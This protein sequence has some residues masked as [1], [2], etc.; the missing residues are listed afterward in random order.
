MKK[1]NNMPTVKRLVVELTP[2]LHA[3]L[4]ALKLPAAHFARALIEMGLTNPNAVIAHAVG[5]GSA[6]IALRHSDPGT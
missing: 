5:L 3:Q 6:S 4:M 2:E 1:E